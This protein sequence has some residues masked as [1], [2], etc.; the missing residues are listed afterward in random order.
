VTQPRAAKPKLP[1]RTEYGAGDPGGRLAWTT[2]QRWLEDARYFWI[3]TA[4]SDGTPHTVPVWAVWRENRLS[5]ST[6]PETL[7]ARNLQLRPQAVAHP[8]SAAEV[9][10]VK[11]GVEKPD[12][13]SLGALV[14]AYEAKY[15]WRLDSDDPGMPF[16]ELKPRRVLAWRIR[17]PCTPFPRPRTLEYVARQ[18][19][20]MMHLC[21]R[22]PFEPVGAR[23]RSDASL[24]SR[25]RCS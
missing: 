3:S 6:S 24:E 4:C 2:V 9:V 1:D 7:T 22:R 15:G 17:T 21:L 20:E 13:R 23:A 14:D 11:G 16:L 12:A 5:F 10:I 18:R 25:V 8:E 19:I